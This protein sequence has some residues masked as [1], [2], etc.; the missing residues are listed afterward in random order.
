MI[1]PDSSLLIQVVNADSPN[2]RA[3]YRWWGDL[4][5]KGEPVGLAWNVILSFLQLS[6]KP[7]I[8]PR[9]LEVHKAWHIIEVWLKNRSCQII[10]PG[11]HHV[12]IFKVLIAESNRE[13]N[14]F[15]DLHLASLAIEHGAE[16]H[17]TNTHFGRI[18]SLRWLNPLAQR[19][20]F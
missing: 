13:G 12:R 4:V 18:Q 2:H 3:A 16:L 11:R 19:L 5:E 8:F 7:G 6:T 15:A 1:I 9:P 10:A 14:G 20:L 17:S